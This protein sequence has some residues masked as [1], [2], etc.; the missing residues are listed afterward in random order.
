[1]LSVSHAATGALIASKLP[2][3]LLYIPL[4]IGVHFL[5][6]A[7]PHWDMGTGLTSGKRT[8]RDA[9][10]LGVIDLI[11]AL[12]VVYFFWQN[13]QTELQTNTWLGAFFAIS[14]DIVESPRTFLKLDF[15]FLKHFHWLHEWV[16]TSTPNMLVGLTPQILLLVVIWFLR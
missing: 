5:E 2:N 3:P 14:P 4:A 12:A 13:G 7:V 8:R 16:H 11:M 15:K 9:A 6:D 10:I 1:M